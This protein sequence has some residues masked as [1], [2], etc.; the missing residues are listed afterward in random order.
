MGV[1]RN[2]AILLLDRPHDL[3]LGCGVKMISRL[4]KQELKVFGHVP[5]AQLQPRGALERPSQLTSP[6]RLLFE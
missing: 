4:S 1:Q 2:I 6:L 3:T 5:V